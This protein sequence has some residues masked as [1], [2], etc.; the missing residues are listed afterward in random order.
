MSRYTYKDELYKRLEVA[1][2]NLNIWKIKRIAQDIINDKSND[3][4]IVNKRGKQRTIVE[5]W[6]VNFT[7]ESEVLFKF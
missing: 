1:F 6:I 4:S 7:D 5:S 3:P 2:P